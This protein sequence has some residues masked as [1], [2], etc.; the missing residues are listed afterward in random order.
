MIPGGGAMVKAGFAA[1]RAGGRVAAK[2]GQS[3]AKLAKGGCN[4]FAPDTGVL[5][6]DGTTQS[7]SDVDVGD[8]VAARDPLSG[9]LS[10]QPVLNVIIGH[11]DKHL[12]GV[13]TS[14]APP[15]Q[16]GVSDSADEGTWIATA[17]H[18]VW[19]V[20]QG[21]TDATALNVGD[22]TVGATGEARVVDRVEDFGWLPGQTVYNLSVANVHTFVVGDV[23]DGTVVHNKSC[24][25]GGVYHLVGSDTG[26][27]LRTG[28]TNNLAR[29]QAEHART[30][31]ANIEFRVLHYSNDR[32]VRRGLEQMAHQRY[33][34]ILNRVSPISRFN[35]R[36]NVYMNAAR[37]FLKG[38]K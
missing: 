37:A 23:G 17:N 32:K 4:S 22:L 14:R 12:I 7:I 33:R 3:V 36:K 10:A 11:G 29:R 15:V 1:A 2:V 13:T 31:S 6:A 30:Y 18:P 26:R 20:G 34:P 9:E 25:Q 5:M 24:P 19:I 16:G 8:L 28:L 21:W 27:T 35:P 38:G